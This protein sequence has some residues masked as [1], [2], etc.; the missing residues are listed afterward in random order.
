MGEIPSS[1]TTSRGPAI[2]VPPA[3]ERGEEPRPVPSTGQQL[4]APPPGAAH[5]TPVT[6]PVPFP[7]GGPDPTTFRLW[8]A[9]YR[10]PRWF[11]PGPRSRADPS[12]AGPDGQAAD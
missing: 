11:T 2:V 5:I 3:R 7:V 1:P 4:P 10:C 8:P 12:S 6:A 9:A